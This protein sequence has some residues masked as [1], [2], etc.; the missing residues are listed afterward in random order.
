MNELN[1]MA[2]REISVLLEGST[3][4]RYEINNELYM[5]E[6]RYRNNIQDVSVLISNLSK[7]TSIIDNKEDVL[8]M[9][10]DLVSEQKNGITETNKIKNSL[11]V[12]QNNNS[13]AGNW[14]LAITKDNQG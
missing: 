2:L 3:K 13:K 9:L 14:V 6:Q 7:E 11:E 4:M 10:R 5:Q 12:L 8:K 1:K